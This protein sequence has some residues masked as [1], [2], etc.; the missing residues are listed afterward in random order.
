MQGVAM[1]PINRS[2]SFSALLSLEPH[3]MSDPWLLIL[4]SLSQ[5]AKK[6]A[7]DAAPEQASDADSSAAEA[8]PKQAPARRR[9]A[10]P[11]AAAAAAKKRTAAEAAAAT[12]EER[13]GQLKRA[14]M[15]VIK[16]EEALQ[17]C[18]KHQVHLCSQ[19]SCSVWYWRA[20]CLNSLTFGGWTLCSRKRAGCIA[21]AA[22]QTL[23]SKVDFIMANLCIVAVQWEVHRMSPRAVEVRGTLRGIGITGT[24]LCRRRRCARPARR[25]GSGWRTSCPMHRSS[26]CAPRGRSRGCSRTHPSQIPF[27]QRRVPHSSGQ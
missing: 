12:E 16:L 25:S 10:V 14:L 11:G 23:F 4:F 5:A 27:P 24:G 8:L 13:T 1:V 26:C 20:W 15:L 18:Y 7:V 17:Q 19:L 6:A 22:W 21:A 2:F 3:H 9:P